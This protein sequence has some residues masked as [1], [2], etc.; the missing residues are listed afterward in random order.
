MV[1]CRTLIFAA[2]CRI[3]ESAILIS[4]SIFLNLFHV[5]LL[6]FTLFLFIIIFARATHTQINVLPLPL[7]SSLSSSVFVFVSVSACVALVCI[8]FYLSPPSFSLFLFLCLF[9]FHLIGWC[10]STRIVGV[11]LHCVLVRA[12]YAAT[13]TIT[14]RIVCG[15]CCSMCTG[16]SP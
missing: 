13:T 4:V 15:C 5:C 6:N 1:I 12:G 16:L 2:I 10:G 14:V 11:F 9:A 8:Y 7:P 3:F